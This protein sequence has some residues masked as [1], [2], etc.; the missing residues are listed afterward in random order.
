MMPT[1]SI[2]SA[3]ALIFAGFFLAIGWSLGLW[4]YSLVATLIARI[5]K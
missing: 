1:I 5:G 3:L 4:V 2:A